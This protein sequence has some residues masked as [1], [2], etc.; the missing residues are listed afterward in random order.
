MNNDIMLGK[1]VVMNFIQKVNSQY[2]FSSMK[3]EDVVNVYSDPRQRDNFL[4]GLGLQYREVLNSNESDLDTAMESLARA[5]NNKVPSQASFH[6]AIRE[7]A[8][9]PSFFVAASTVISGTAS[10]V[11]GGAVE[12]GNTLI[13]TAGIIKALFPFVVVGG[14]LFVSYSYIK[15]VS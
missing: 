1:I 11:L 12:V 9:N 5:C 8:L 14:L 7:K 4:D 13:N 6:K 10:E 15:K 2:F 3:F